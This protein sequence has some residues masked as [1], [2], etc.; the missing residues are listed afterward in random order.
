MTAYAFLNPVLCSLRYTQTEVKKE[1][2][3]S[4]D[5]CATGWM[6]RDSIQILAIFRFNEGKLQARN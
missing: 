3:I 2:M 6:K 4:T 1:V 5:A